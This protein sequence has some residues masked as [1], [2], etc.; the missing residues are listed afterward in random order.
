MAVK[1][2]IE[3]KL[4]SKMVEKFQAT[5]DVKTAIHLTALAGAAICAALP[6]GV[7]VGALRLGPV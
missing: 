7:D 3:N 1:A 2:A 6:I 4:E 5:S